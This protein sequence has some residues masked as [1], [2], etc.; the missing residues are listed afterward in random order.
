MRRNAHGE[1]LWLIRAG[2]PR[3]RAV[4]PPPSEN[5]TG[6]TRGTANCQNQ[7]CPHVLTSLHRDSDFIARPSEINQPHRNRGTRH[8]AIRHD[9][10]HL[11]ESWKP[12]SIAEIENLRRL[13]TDEDS[14]RDDAALSQVRG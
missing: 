12:G 11:V 3:P 6:T 8:D 14:R 2:E 10:V 5:R 13:S 4:H 9:D 7:D 1:T